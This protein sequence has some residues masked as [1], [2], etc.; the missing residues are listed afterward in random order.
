MNIE[1]IEQSLMKLFN[2]DK[3]I[4]QKRHIVFWYDENG[5]FRDDIDL[6]NLPNVIIH[7]L[8]DNFFYT[9]FLL[10]KEDTEN[11][12]LIYSDTAKPN[13]D[14]NWFLDILLYSQEFSA[15]K[16]SVILNDLWITDLG[17]K[18]II[19]NHI[20]FFSSKKRTD[21][22]I[23]LNLDKNN[24]TSIELSML[25]VLAWEKTTNIDD[26]LKKIILAWLDDNKILEEFKKYDLLYIFWKH[27]RFFYWYNKETWD[28]RDLFT[29]FIISNINFTWEYELP[30][31][32]KWFSKCSNQSNVFINHFMNHKIDYKYYREISNEISNELNIFNKIVVDLNKIKNIETIS[33]VDKTI[34]LSITNSLKNKNTDFNYF[35]D[36]INLRKNKHW[37][38]EFESQYETLFNAIKIFEF[39]ETY[40][41]WFNQITAKWLFEDYTNDLYRMDTYYRLFNYNFDK[42]QF[43]LKNNYLSDLQKEIEWI[44]TNWFLDELTKKQIS[45]LR[46][47][48]LDNRYI[49]W[50]AK[51]SDFYISEVS[52]ILKWKNTERVFVI[53]SDALRYESAKELVS[54]LEKERWITSI[55]SMQ[56]VI[57]SYTKLWM[58][59]LLPHENIIIDNSWRILV[60]NM[61]STSTEWKNKILNKYLESIAITWK[62]L[63]NYSQNE[64]RD[65]FREKKVVYIYHNIIDSIWDDSKTEHK[66]FEACNSAIVEL[67]DIVKKITNSWNWINVLITADHWFIYKR[68]ALVESD[69]I[70][71]EKV[72]KIDNNRRF[73]LTLDKKEIDWTIK[74]DMWYIWNPWIKAILPNGN[75]RF[76]IQWWGANFVHGS[77]TLQEIVIPIVNFKYQK[78]LKAWMTDFKKEVDIVLSNTNRVINWNIF[79]LVFHQSQAIVWKLLEWIYRVSLWDISWNE[80]IIISDEKTIIADKTSD[81]IEDRIFKLQLTLKSWNYDK[82]KDYRLRIFSDWK[83]PKEKEW[84]DFT[85][86]ILIQNDFDSI[87]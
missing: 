42:T 26:I 12:Y 8:N 25:W 13:A 64:A 70:S 32:L 49:G 55:S 65:I 4:Y 34:L 53:I 72:T 74:I 7:I 35:I 78:D 51:Q 60:D 69:K 75:S 87:F 14:N 29:S 37:Y 71:L 11:N 17:V 86:D 23:K 40:K 10:E 19:N 50:I 22:F 67:K 73:I 77:L 76:K 24:L 46:A 5:D 3:D 43:S 28:L 80:P 48:W 16:S 45:L 2:V 6:L 1:Q 62:E 52:S 30:L 61:D 54:L 84:Y 85:I 47:D 83:T 31:H 27:I 59:S 41:S 56:W 18:E 66:T 44:Y 9:K 36:I 57:P 79:T 20:K 38:D 39:Q 81:K 63:S 15:D 33:W 68:E 21:D 82:K 58:A